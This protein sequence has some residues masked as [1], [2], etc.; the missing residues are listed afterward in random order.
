[1]EFKEKQAIYLQIA[2]YVCDHILN[3]HWQSGIRVLSVRELAVKLEVNPN[4]V[5]RAY[6][7]LLKQ[8]ILLNKRG[9]GFFVDQNASVRILTFRKQRF[10]EE[11]LPHIIKNMHLLGIKINEIEEKYN[12]FQYSQYLSLNDNTYEKSNE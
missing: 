11:E 2:D 9:I 1:M 4:T 7:T 10:L 3:G 5:M 6:D 12:E 8:Q